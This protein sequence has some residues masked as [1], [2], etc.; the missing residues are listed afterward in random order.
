MSIVAMK[1]KS[2]KMNRPI[3]GGG[4]GFSLHG[5]HSTTT[6]STSGLMASKVKRNLNHVGQYNGSTP[7]LRESGEIFYPDY[8]PWESQGLY[9]KKI[10]LDA[11]N[12]GHR[13]STKMTD[14]GTAACADN[15]CNRG[16]V[17]TL[18][19]SEHVHGA[20]PS[21]QYTRTLPNCQCPSES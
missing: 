14:A 18:T 13:G 9:I 1:R 12:Q 21:G 4:N 20:I 3:S 7:K 16:K 5:A 6:M 17:P 2:R 8:A 19:K 15:D 10:A 11:E